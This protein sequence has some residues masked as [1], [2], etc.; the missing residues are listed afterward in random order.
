M[1]VQL[2][3]AEGLRREMRVTIPAERLE[4]AMGERLKKIARTAKIAGFRPGKAP[5]K[6]I[7]KQYGAQARSEVVGDLVQ[8]TYPEAIDK[9]GVEP[10]GQPQV[11]I[12]AESVGAD[13]QYLARFEVYPK[14][15]LSGLDK[16]KIEKPEVEVTDAD[17]DKLI[18]SLRKA[19]RELTAVERP[20]Q[21]GDVCIVDFL[22]KLDGEAFSGGKGDDTELE[23]GSGR[24]LPD[25]E[26]GV[27]GHSAGESFTID[28]SFPEDYQAEDLKGKTAQFEITLKSVKEPKLPEIDAEFLKAHNVEADAGEQGLKD[29]CRDALTKERDKAVT[30]RL[31]SQALDQLLDK[32]EI[33]VPEALVLQEIP[34]LRQEAAQR[35]NAAQLKPEQVSQMFPDDLFMATA[36]RRVSLGLL[37][38][39]VIKEREIKLDAARV[40]QTLDG[41]A[42]DYEHPD[43][44]KQY[45]RGNPQ[46][47]QGLNAMV[48][49]EQVVDSLLDGVKQKSVKLSLDELL[50]ATKAGQ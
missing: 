49:E 41:I 17:V 39:E 27:I 47:L 16:L 5:M 34:R 31:K 3:N 6:V 2:D 4:R 44:I 30:N 19:K 32:N 29:K 20:A 22:G 12:T 11:E 7:E 45:Y 28:V 42:N 24:F 10:A 35:F 50:N 18:L 46:L 15:E 43:Q 25:M 8:S 37:I 36:K 48:M 13:L 21:D 26:K 9:A 14:I 1:E 23:I 40:E 33:E 38:A